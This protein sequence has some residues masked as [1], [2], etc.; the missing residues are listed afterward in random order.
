VQFA[1]QHKN[2]AQSP[3]ANLAQK[4]CARL[5][6]FRG[7]D[8]MSTPPLQSLIDRLNQIDARLITVQRLLEALTALIDADPEEDD[9]AMSLDGPVEGAGERDQSQPL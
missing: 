3:S 7:P 2:D 6:R 9:A 4:F 8:A 1:A 5:F